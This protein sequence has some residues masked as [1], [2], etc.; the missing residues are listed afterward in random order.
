MMVSRPYQHLA[1]THT[2]MVKARQ[3]FTIYG[4]FPVRG[5]YPPL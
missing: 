3:H 4:K 1:I 5:D 2:L